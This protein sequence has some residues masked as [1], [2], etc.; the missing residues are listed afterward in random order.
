MQLVAGWHL[1][2][3]R[4]ADTLLSDAFDCSAYGLETS[5]GLVLFDAGVGRDTATL[6]DALA[7]AGLAE[8]PR[9]LLITHGH[10]DHSGGAAAIVARTGAR[11]HTGRQT[12]V[13]LERGD[14]TAISLGPARDAGL[15]P[16]D[17]RLQPRRVDQQ[18]VDGDTLTIGEAEISVVA[19]PGHSADHVSYLVRAHGVT[20]LVA[21]DALFSGG[22]VMLQ[23]TWDSSVAATCATI[24]RLAVLEFDLLLPGHGPPLLTDGRRAA[25]LAMQRVSRFLPPLNLV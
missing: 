12:A 7:R 22:E 8:G 1:V 9:H 21:G 25:D 18:L 19:T 4:H 2:L 6:P 5:D 11:L 23:D 13:W 15:Y 16:A 10:L 14:E 17:L 20:A 3:G 24:R